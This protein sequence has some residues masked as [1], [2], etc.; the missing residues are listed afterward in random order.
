M[1]ITGASGLLGTLLR[2][3]LTTAGHQVQTLVR[4][5]ADAAAGEIAWDP[6]AGTLDAAAMAALEGVDAVVHLSGE[7]VGAG[8]WTA[9]RKERFVSSRVGPTQVLCRALAKLSRK[10]RVLVSAA[11]IGF[12]GDRGDELLT[13]ASPKGVGFFPDLCAAWESATAPAQ[14]AGI[15]VVHLRIGVVLSPRGGALAK[16]I[17]PFKLGLGG[18]I[19]GGRQYLSCIAS[20]DLLN[21]IHEAIFNDRLDGPVNAVG[22]EPVTQRQ[23]AKTLGRVLGRPAVLPDA[24]GGGETPVRRDGPD[25][26]VGGGQSV[27]DEIAVGRLRVPVPDAGIGV[28]PNWAGK[29][30]RR[31]G[32]KKGKSCEFTRG[33]STFYAKERFPGLYRADF[34]QAAGGLLSRHPQSAAAA[35]A[36][37]CSTLLQPGMTAVTAGW[38]RHQASAQRAIGTPG[39]TSFPPPA[40]PRPGGAGAWPGLA[41]AGVVGGEGVAGVVLAAEQAAGQWHPGQHAQPLPLAR[42]QTRG[43]RGRG[44]GDCRPP[45]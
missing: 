13:E 7:N 28:A 38:R 35:F 26:A 18:P 23:F 5:A 3:T 20:D 25:A 19:G 17:R 22:P 32:G 41:G 45:E 9:E 12:Y 14:E 21:I 43:L 8:R 4:R 6:S 33:Q 42:G 40:A 2:P 39:G 10:P 15:R 11:A 30:S 37:I 44:R 27:A 16:M 29:C 24:G 34:A 31:V 1:A 36:S